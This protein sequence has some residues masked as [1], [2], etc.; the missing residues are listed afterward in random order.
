MTLSQGC[1]KV[2]CHKVGCHKLV[3][4]LQMQGTFVG[5]YY[6]GICCFL[7]GHKELT[8]NEALVEMKEMVHPPTR[9]VQDMAAA[10]F[11]GIPI[12]SHR[13]G[14]HG[15]HVALY[16]LEFANF[17]RNCI[18]IRL[19]KED[20]SFTTEYCNAMSKICGTED[21]RKDKSNELLTSYFKLGKIEPKVFPNQHGPLQKDAVCLGMLKKQHISNISV[22]LA[23][24]VVTAF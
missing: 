13:N 3:D 19:T 5:A 23:W 4:G 17:S 24:V 6:T 14:Q 12:W 2:G 8:L 16:C 9:I 21:E 7:S 11:K 20:T 1:H 22:K 10:E 18:S 15:N